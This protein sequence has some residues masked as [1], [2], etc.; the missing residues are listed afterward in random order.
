[1]PETTG[2]EGL[3]IE[4]L[5]IEGLTTE[6]LRALRYFE[7]LTDGDAA[8]VLQEADRVTLAPGE[9]LF[10]QGDAG[11]SVFLLVC[12]RMQIR[13]DVPGPE[14]HIL[15]ELEAGAIFGEMALLLDRPRTG[16]A[17]ALEECELLRLYRDKFRADLHG[18]ARWAQRLLMATAQVLAQ[19]LDSVNCQVIEL[20]QAVREVEAEASASS[21]P[22]VARVA[23]LDQLRK[24]LFSEWSF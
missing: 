6:R 20:S 24:R 10:H 2:T 17:C 1:M 22:P 5:T 15:A 18:G 14:D 3:T 21:M 11:D 8:H 9:V 4:G 23:E 19:R 7:T 12:G 16:S 13:V